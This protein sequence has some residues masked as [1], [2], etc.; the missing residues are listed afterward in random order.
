MQ[1]KLYVQV[2][3]GRIRLGLEHDDAIWSTTA[4]IETQDKVFVSPPEKTRLLKCQLQ[5]LVQ[6]TIL[7]KMVKRW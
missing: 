2:T 7:L 4:T 6:L 5:L 3:Q 1:I